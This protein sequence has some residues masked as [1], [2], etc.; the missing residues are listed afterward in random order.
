M[1]DQEL[2]ER[3][4]EW[5]RP[6]QDTVP[7]PVAV[8][9]TRARRRVI[10]RG[11]AGAMTLAAAG[12][13]AGLV[14][15][16]LPGAGASHPAPAAPGGPGPVT[17][18]GSTVHGSTVPGN[19]V[20]GSTVPDN[21]APIG[22]LSAQTVPPGSPYLVELGNRQAN[23]MNAATGTLIQTAVAPVSGYGFTWVAA[24]AGDRA[25][26]LAAQTDGYTATKF[27]VLHVNPDG[28]MAGLTPV[29]GAAGVSGEIYGMA[30]SPDGTEL[31]VTTTPQGGIPPSR[32][33][34]FGISGG[35]TRSWT[36]AAGF[37]AT[38]SFA[39][40]GRLGFAWEPA[41]ATVTGGGVQFRTLRLSTLAAGGTG[42]LIGDS[43]V[44]VNSVAAGLGGQFTADGSTVLAISQTATKA[45]LEEFSARSGQLQ[46]SVLLA[47]PPAST[48]QFCG[49]LWASA[50]GRQVLTQCGTVQAWVAGGQV[51][52]VRLAVT[53]T[54]SQVG[55]ANTFAW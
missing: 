50:D 5:A 52:P 54:A 19:A 11:A 12:V 13:A 10:R 44:T 34:V 38:L 36:S 9:R 35:G 32:V 26:V 45:W 47:S 49:V 27:Y 39:G 16:G 2:R 24:T 23:I 3:F 18:P 41:D 17:V 8:I 53:V 37:P 55:W 40:D 42:S 48:T 6:L 29:S 21:T 14:I 43:T 7:P 30:V 1:Q 22:S 33:W 20:P 31:A 51:I 46:D 15:G 25:F 4:A 28:T